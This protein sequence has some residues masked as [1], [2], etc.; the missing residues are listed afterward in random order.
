MPSIADSGLGFEEK[1]AAPKISV[2]YLTIAAE[3]IEI[4][5]SVFVAAGIETMPLLMTISTPP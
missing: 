4:V 3:L 2:I 1:R 5:F